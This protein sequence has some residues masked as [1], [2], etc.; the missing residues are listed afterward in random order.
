MS[1]RK[2]LNIATG[3]I[4]HEKSLV[5][6]LV[7]NPR[8]MEMLIGKRSHHGS[9]PGIW[10]HIG[11]KVDETD[12]SIEAALAREIG[13]ELGDKFQFDIK[14]FLFNSRYTPPDDSK[15]I[16]DLNVFLV[17]HLGGPV[18]LTRE[19]ADC[20]WV[21]FDA[22]EDMMTLEMISPADCAIIE[23]LQKHR[24]EINEGF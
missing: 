1:T 21:K 13:E 11:G 5:N 24:Y 12:V 18:Q 22:L 16:I 8:K 6:G 20:G 9:N 7:T 17:H 4:I 3:I 23:W 19:H 2:A 10:E 14:R 15:P